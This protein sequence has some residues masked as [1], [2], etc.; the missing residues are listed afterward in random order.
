MTSPDPQTPQ[1]VDAEEEQPEETPVYFVSF[2]RLAALNRSPIVLIAGRR[3]PSCPSFQQP[4]HELSD[5]QALVDEIAQHCAEEEG[6]I[7]SSMTIQEIVFRTILARRN[8]PTSLTE[9]HH[10]LTER[11][12]TPI[13]PINITEERLQRVLDTD[14]FYGFA[15][16]V[17]GG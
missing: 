9:L 5:P 4:D 11:W 17:N 6:F 15:R 3:M 16:V 8:S 13:R 14:D 2:E 12:S 10:E 7:Q 1:S